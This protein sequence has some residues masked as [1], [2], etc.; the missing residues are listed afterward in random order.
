MPVVTV[1]LDDDVAEILKLLGE[2]RIDGMKSQSDAFRAGVRHF[3][4]SLNMD[5]LRAFMEKKHAEQMDAL[6]RF[7]EQRDQHDAPAAE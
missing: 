3:I 6:N 1:R 7:I 2:L 4:A 5:E